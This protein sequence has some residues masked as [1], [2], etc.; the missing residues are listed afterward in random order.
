MTFPVRHGIAFRSALAVIGFT[1]LAGICSVA[2]IGAVA[3]DRTREDIAARLQALLETVANTTSAACFVEDKVLA[4]DIAE[5][6]LKNSVVL[7]VIIRSNSGELAN[8]SR[9]PSARP[10]GA[11][12]DGAIS[13][14]IYSPFDAAT[15]VGEILI[16]PNV[17]ELGRM[18]REELV[19][20]GSA[21]FL[22]L[23]AII[24]AA[25]YAAFRWIVWPM[26]SMSDQLHRLSNEQSGSLPMPA[27]HETT[28]IG[29]LVV[30][31]NELIEHLAQARA[32]A[33]S[34]SRAKGDFLAH[35]SH[36]IRTP[37]NAVVGMAHLA[38]KTSLTPKQRDYVEKIRGAGRH[39][40][41]LV[42]DILDFAKIEAGKLKLESSSFNLTELIE[43]ITTMAGLKADEKGL[44]LQVDI[45]PEIPSRLSGDSVRISQILLNYVN[46]AIKFTDRGS[47][48]LR[49][50]LIEQ[51]GTQ[52]RIRF[53]VKDTGPGLSAE[54]MGRLFQSF[55][56]AEASISRKF[57]GSGLGLVISKE[58][59]ELMG[60]EVG[61]DSILGQGS[62]FWACVNV[63]L[64][65]DDDS[66]PAMPADSEFAGAPSGLEGRRIL[67]AEDNLLNQQIAREILEEFGLHIRIANNGREAIDLLHSEAFD[68]VL[69]DVRMPDLDGI[70]ATRRI[71]AE[72]QFAGLPIIAMTANARAEDRDECLLAGMSDFISK[73]V[74]P[75]QFFRI[76]SKWLCPAGESL[77]IVSDG[78]EE[79]G[80][81]PSAG[82]EPE[83]DT[84]ILSL[85]ARHDVQK[86]Q[87]LG[88]IFLESTRVG[89]GQLGEAVR[90]G[91][92]AVLLDLAHAYKSSSRS[93]GAVH[94]A[95]LFGHLEAAA[96]AGDETQAKLLG[97]EI[98][99][100]WQRIEIELAA[101][102]AEGIGD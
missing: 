80:K 23:I 12:L 102:L 88:N 53:E 29:R 9:Q 73:P 33:E 89:V 78:R 64:A 34:A 67:L 87:R 35:M 38:L 52:C 1:L 4:K 7:R 45:D 93:M 37:I 84:Q 71:R 30:D 79:Q 11:V 85:L 24:L 92:M 17:D 100:T 90:Q 25:I 47:V 43:R 55:E 44:L 101:F 16:E 42:N 61:V 36:E 32:Q 10:G 28:E 70:E 48:C 72:T 65:S 60:G 15:E 46:N 63:G 3:F 98:A 91:Q 5:G 39:L 2:I 75:A 31:I 94:L 66:I 14:K 57:G 21:L 77:A 58:L 41:N 19:F 59:A 74:D 95:D 86:I 56:Q 68:G 54:Q 18:H 50:R 27:G 99:E 83:I 40:L 97:R 20:I 62:T 82:A 69:M 6:L 22:Q 81:E 26:K 8:V 76:L 13:R 51:E 49:A 96:K